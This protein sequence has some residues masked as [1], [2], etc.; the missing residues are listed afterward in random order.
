MSFILKT[1]E[2]IL[3]RHIKDGVLVKRPLH[4]NQFAYRAGMPTETALFQVVHRLEKSL[5]NKEIA[6]GAFLDIE[7]AF[8]NTSFKVI[9]TAARERGLE[10]TSCR[11]VRS[12][13]QSRHIHTSIM[14]SSLTAKVVGGCCPQGVVLSPFLWN[15]IFDRL[16]N[17]TNDLNFST[18]GY[19]DDI[20]ITV[21]R[22][23]M[24]TVREIMQEALNVVVKWAVKEG[25]SIS[26]LKTV[27]LPFTN[28]RNTEGLGPLKLYGKELT[29]LGVTFDS[30]LSWNQHLEKIINKRTPLLR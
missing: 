13:L 14:G 8:H 10:E 4:Q 30:K 11:W 22:K 29:M 27:T 12:M 7:G 21:Q 20:V 15:L 26:P 28:R 2:N 18:F 9:I 16:L 24:H 6:L 25:L 23:F 3:D 19:A 5:Q 1:L 17:I